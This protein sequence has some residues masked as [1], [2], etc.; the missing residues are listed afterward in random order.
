VRRRDEVRLPSPHSKGRA[1]SWDIVSPKVRSAMMS[2][3][4]GKNT[5]PE[6]LV[7]SLLYRC[8]YRFRIHVKSLPGR[9]DIVL[10][11]RRA[12][13][14]VHGCFWHRHSCGLAYQPKTRAR[15]WAE[16]FAGNVERD[17]RYRRRL[18]NLGWRV[19]VVWECEID[20]EL[21][22]GRRLR[23]FLTDS[24]QVATSGSHARTKSRNRPS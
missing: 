10:H 5:T 15:F 11:S 18:T 23:E 3:I 14:F 16:K 2:R 9:P 13:I 24:M 17:R 19:L 7:R 21:K 8:G 4:R 20:D 22:L 6:L 12:V 1:K